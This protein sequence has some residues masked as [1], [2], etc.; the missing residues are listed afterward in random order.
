MAPATHNPA[1]EQLRQKVKSQAGMIVDLL[2]YIRVLRDEH[3]AQS[4]VLNVALEQSHESHREYQ[5]LKARYRVLP[6]ERGARLDRPN[7]AF[8]PDQEAA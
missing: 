7:G 4:L 8:S 3:V 5:R 6:D 1:L 2:R